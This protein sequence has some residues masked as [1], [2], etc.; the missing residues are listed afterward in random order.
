MFFKLEIMI[1]IYIYG[2]LLIVDILIKMMVLG[3]YFYHS[4]YNCLRITYFQVHI[5]R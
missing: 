4:S 1:Y 2:K 3:N 5:K